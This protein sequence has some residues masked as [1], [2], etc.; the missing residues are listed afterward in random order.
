M[1]VRSLSE[2]KQQLCRLVPGWVT[3]AVRVALL[4]DCSDTARSI[5][6]GNNAA[7]TCTSMRRSTLCPRPVLLILVFDCSESCKNQD[8]RKVSTLFHFQQINAY[9]SDFNYKYASWISF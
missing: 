6:L 4:I 9:F 1:A 3:A 2:V 5:T 7:C 8:D